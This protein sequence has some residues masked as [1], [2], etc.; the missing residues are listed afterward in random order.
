M[1]IRQHKLWILLFH[2]RLRTSN[3][4]EYHGILVTGKL[5]ITGLAV[6]QSA[7]LCSLGNR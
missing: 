3:T 2:N 4:V 7:A 5:H 6:L 1:F